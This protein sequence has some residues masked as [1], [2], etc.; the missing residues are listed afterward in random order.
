MVSRAPIGLLVMPLG[1]GRA[2]VVE[3]Q[4]F[5]LGSERYDVSV[6]ARF[7]VM[8][9]REL[10]WGER[11]VTSAEDLL[12]PSY[13]PPS[14]VFHGAVSG[15]TACEFG[16]HIEDQ[17][18]VRY[19]LGPQ[20]AFSNFLTVCWTGDPTARLSGAEGHRAASTGKS[21]IPYS[22]FDGEW[23]SGPGADEV[24]TGVGPIHWSRDYRHSI[25]TPAGGGLLAVRVGPSHVA[26]PMELARIAESVVVRLGQ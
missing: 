6:P 16:L 13:L 3:A 24:N 8:R 15:H 22:Y 10:V 11:I 21:P 7:G 26:D 1:S 25:T 18:A 23:A 2:I 9:A 4:L 20:F 12:K 5:L 19:Y 17:V 14:A